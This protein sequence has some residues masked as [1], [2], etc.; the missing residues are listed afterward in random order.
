M[1]KF[2]WN[3]EKL[4][5]AVEH[6][7]NYQDVLRC[8]GIISNGNNNVT[9]KKKIELFGIDISHFTFAPKHRSK[10]KT[11]QEYLVKGVRVCQHNL[12]K[13]LLSEGVK[14][15]ICEIC[16][17]SE[18]NG[19]PLNMELHHKDGDFLNNTLENL[20]MICP[21]CHSQTE[22]YR[23]S[24]IKDAKAD[25]HRCIDC[26]ARVNKHSIRC[27]RCSAK[28]RLGKGAKISMTIEQYLEYKQNGYSN[29][30]IANIYGVSETAIRK[31]VR[32]RDIA[33]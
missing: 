18:W 25:A 19:K 8:L 30:R 16:G 28:N 15:N 21:N 9:L 26:G 24:E 6:S 3:E 4:R 31:W 13:R 23:R 1:E 14:Q 20:I 17:V 33:G 5:K 29:L 10:R 2:D 12:K 7:Q 11:L 32:K 22:N 27:T